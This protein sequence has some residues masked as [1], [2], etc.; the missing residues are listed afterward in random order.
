MC[1]PP[2]FKNN[3]QNIEKY[4]YIYVYVCGIWETIST[5]EFFFFLNDM[6]HLSIYLYLYYL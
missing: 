4:I 2:T 5:F 6:L 3:F 1:M